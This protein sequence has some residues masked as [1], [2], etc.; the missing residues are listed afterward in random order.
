MPTH[1]LIEGADTGSYRE[2]NSIKGEPRSFSFIP[3]CCLLLL[4]VTIRGG[5]SSKIGPTSWMGPEA[6]VSWMLA[7]WWISEDLL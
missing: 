1:F 7:Y 2:L 3:L 4:T 5:G 6:S